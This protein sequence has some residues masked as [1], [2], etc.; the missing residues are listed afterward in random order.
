MNW[1]MY[2]NLLSCYDN[3]NIHVVYI[4]K[5]RRIFVMLYNVVIF[6]AKILQ[7]E[8]KYILKVSC[9]FTMHRYSFNL[10]KQSCYIIRKRNIASYRTTHALLLDNFWRIIYY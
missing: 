2:I 9:V 4:E 6:L 5:E 10:L 7:N 1:L 8:Y 3:K